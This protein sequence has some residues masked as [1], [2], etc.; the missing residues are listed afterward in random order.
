MR[1]QV[2]WRESSKSKIQGWFCDCDDEERSGAERV[3]NYVIRS[4]LRQESRASGRVLTRA[5]RLAA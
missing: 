5:F 4:K 3:G 2:D 1:L